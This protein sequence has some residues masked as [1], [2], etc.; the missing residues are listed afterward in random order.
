MRLIETTINR[1]TV[2][3]AVRAESLWMYPLI[4]L[5]QRE[6]GF[7]L[8]GDAFVNGMLEVTEVS[9]SG[10]VPTLRVTNSGPRPVLL[11]DGE[12]LIGAK[13]NRVLNATVLVQAKATIDVPVS[14]VEAGRWGY[15]S[16]KFRAADWIMYSEGRARKMR[17]VHE[18]LKRDSRR[19]DQGDVWDNIS[20]KS[21]R[22]GAESPTSAQEAMYVKYRRRLDEDVDTLKT[23]E[24]QVGAVF[25]I[26]GRITGHE[27]L[28]NSKAFR[29]V[30]PKIVR[31]YA[32]DALDPELRAKATSPDDIQLFRSNLRQTDYAVGKTRLR[33][34]PDGP[35][36]ARRIAVERLVSD[37]LP[38]EP[39]GL[40]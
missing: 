2:R 21:V 36:R 30:Y 11:I 5:D 28:G 14:C 9:E 16:R 34:R 25:A 19:G 27:L 40:V 31:S 24:G 6:N 10:A 8:A 23:F 29:A 37:F 26:H 20:A 7:D 22:M 4:D 18:S 38:G 17:N 13:Q 39:G 15:R 33:P 12:E 3:P 35:H 32:I 1:L